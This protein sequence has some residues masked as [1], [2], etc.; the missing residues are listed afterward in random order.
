MY[1][2]FSFLSLAE[3]GHFLLLRE[4]INIRKQ[5]ME[6]GEKTARG[7]DGISA[8]LSMKNIWTRFSKNLTD[9]LSSCSGRHEKSLQQIMQ[10]PAL[11]ILIK[12]EVIK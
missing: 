7:I 11:K 10:I 8:N 6:E 2:L 12:N 1:K 5:W 9:M 3:V 4:H